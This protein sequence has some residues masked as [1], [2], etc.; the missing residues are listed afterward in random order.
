MSKKL[1]IKTLPKKNRVKE[2]FDKTVGHTADLK[3]ECAAFTGLAI[4][5]IHKLYNTPQQALNSNSIMGLMAFF[6][7]KW[8]REVSLDEIAVYRNSDN[9]GVAVSKALKEKTI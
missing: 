1:N 9:I 6:K 2:C 5:T 3:K 7:S 4:S 8:G